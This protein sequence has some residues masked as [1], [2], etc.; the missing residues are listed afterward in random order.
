MTILVLKI[1]NTVKDKENIYSTVLEDLQK[2]MTLSPI[3][4][5]EIDIDEK[6]VIPIGGRYY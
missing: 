1:S 5:I 6:H 4:K 3:H 2:S